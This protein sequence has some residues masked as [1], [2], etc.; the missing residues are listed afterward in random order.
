MSTIGRSSLPRCVEEIEPQL[1]HG[2]ELII[3]SDGVPLDMSTDATVITLPYRT[4]DY[5]CTPKA[6]GAL[7][8]RGDVIWFVD[9]DDWYAD[10]ALQ[11]I[12][13]GAEENPGRL[14]IFRMLHRRLGRVLGHSVSI[15]AVGAPQMVVPNSPLLPSW[16]RAWEPGRMTPDHSMIQMVVE[17]FGEPV[18]LDNI[19]AICERQN[20]G[21]DF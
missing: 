7:L 5:G 21:A 9:D 19:I 1:Q 16:K 6:V 3:V 11:W 18:Y 17:A 15:C 12:R 8:A 2:D 10:R 14:L 13:A 20:F 4:N